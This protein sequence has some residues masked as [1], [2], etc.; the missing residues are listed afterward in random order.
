MRAPKGWLFWSALAAVLLVVHFVVEFGAWA[1][2]PGN[3][4]P[5]SGESAIPWQVASFPLFLIMG[6]RSDVFFWETMVA[7]SLIWSIGLTLV[8]KAVSTARHAL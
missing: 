8:A 2:H 6:H 4:V 1:T 3:S 5:G 7:N